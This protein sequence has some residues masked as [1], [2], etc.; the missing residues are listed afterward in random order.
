[1]RNLQLVTTLIAE[2]W[3]SLVKIFECTNIFQ[4]DIRVCGPP[5]CREPLEPRI[6]RW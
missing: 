2:F 1:M 3:M 4:R 6:H 5:V